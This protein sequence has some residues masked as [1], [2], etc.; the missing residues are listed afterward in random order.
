MT[1]KGKCSV[2]G[3]NGVGEWGMEREGNDGGVMEE[4]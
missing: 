1:S 3:R 4:G 2:N